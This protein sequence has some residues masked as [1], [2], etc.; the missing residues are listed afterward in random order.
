MVQ[1]TAY[2]VG[3]LPHLSKL[4]VSMYSGRML[5]Q[6]KES[7]ILQRFRPLTCQLYRLVLPWELTEG[8]ALSRDIDHSA[9][10]AQALVDVLQGCV[11]HQRGPRL[12][13]A[14]VVA[15]AAAVGSTTSAAASTSR[16]YAPINQSL[17]SKQAHLALL[18]LSQYPQV[19]GQVDPP[20]VP[21]HHHPDGGDEPVDQRHASPMQAGGVGRHDGARGAMAPG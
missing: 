7:G 16:L 2:N 21:R 4:T 11:N 12:D 17:N 15:L 20:R 9:E 1:F 6:L 10:Q 18:H 19:V 5:K 13:S 8:E 3:L 14:M